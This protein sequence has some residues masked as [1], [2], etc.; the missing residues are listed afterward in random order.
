MLNEQPYQWGKVCGNYDRDY[1][2]EPRYEDPTPEVPK[3]TDAERVA[4]EDAMIALYNE[5]PPGKRS[6]ILSALRR[7]GSR[8]IADQL[9]RGEL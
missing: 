5:V 1:L 3:F 9:E 8:S 4:V 2:R 7:M 6:D